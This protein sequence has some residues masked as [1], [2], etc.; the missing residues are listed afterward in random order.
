MSESAKKQEILEASQDPVFDSGVFD[1]IQRETPEQ[2]R[3]LKF[4]LPEYLRTPEHL[5]MVEDFFEVEV[6]RQLAYRVWRPKNTEVQVMLVR[7]LGLN[8][9]ARWTTQFEFHRWA[10][11]LNAAVCVVEPSG[12]GL[13]DGLWLD[14]PRGF[15]GIVDDVAR[16]VEFARDLHPEVPLFVL[17]ES[18]GGA[19]AFDLATKHADTLLRLGHRG[20][21]LAAPMLGIVDVPPAPVVWTLKALTT[22]VPKW[23]MVARPSLLCGLCW[24]QDIRLRIRNGPF[25]SPGK[26]RLRMARE[27]LDASLRIESEL[28]TLDTPFL[29]L[30]GSEDHVTCPKQSQ[31]LYERSRAEDKTM[32]LVEQGPHCLFLEPSTRDHA[33]DLVVDWVRQRL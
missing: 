24:D 27:L 3:A 28:H 26:V 16:F 25:F 7:V 1:A 13:S 4:E 10:T 29:V 8:D 19:V 14:L 23:R 33:R 32:H 18:M 21:I 9:S 22:L 15:S 6:G 12:H 2:R 20:T 30:H 5:E 17:G 11:E 31:Q